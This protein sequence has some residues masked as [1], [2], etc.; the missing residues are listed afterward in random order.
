MIVDIHD[1]VQELVSEYQTDDPQE[2]AESLGLIIRFS[3]LGNLKGL[4]LLTQGFRYI[5]VNSNISKSMKQ[6]VIAHEMGHDQLHRELAALGQLNAFS[7][8]DMSSR[9]EMEA[10]TFAANLLITDNALL[11]AAEETEYTTAGLAKLL[12]VPHQL[13]LIKM[14]DMNKRGY[15]FNLDYIPQG[16]FLADI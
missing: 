2:L 9:P 14:R 5:I 13:L 6:L 1:K 4:Y 15:E 8:Y 3:N 12:C 16:S 7:L 10:N 11:S